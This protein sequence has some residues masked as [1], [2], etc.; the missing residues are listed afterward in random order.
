MRVTNDCP[1]FKKNQQLYWIEATYPN[2]TIQFQRKTYFFRHM[3]PSI[4][5]VIYTIESSPIVKEYKDNIRKYLTYWACHQVSV[6]T[7]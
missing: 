7:H 2:R 6:Q 3:R 5:G 4:N 1:A